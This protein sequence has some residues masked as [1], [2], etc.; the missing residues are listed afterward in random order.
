MALK[1]C[2]SGL[3]SSDR[4]GDE[5]GWGAKEEEWNASSRLR[6]TRDASGE[7]EGQREGRGDK[8]ERK[9]SQPCRGK[10]A[11]EV[12]TARDAVRV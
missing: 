6:H 11:I 12:S 2:S 3:W 4:W 9:V 1:A 10:H 7:G 8:Q 5:N